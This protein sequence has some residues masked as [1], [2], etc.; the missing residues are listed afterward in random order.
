MEYHASVSWSPTSVLQ[1]WSR[2]IFL[3]LKWTWRQGPWSGKV[4]MGLV[5]SDNVLDLA[6]V[7]HQC[8]KQRWNLIHNLSVTVWESVPGTKSCGQPIGL[9]LG[10]EVGCD[11]IYQKPLWLS[12]LTFSFKVSVLACNLVLEIMDRE[13]PGARVRPKLTLNKFTTQNCHFSNFQF[14]HL[15]SCIHVPYLYHC[16]L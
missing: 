13:E 4:V 14:I 7:H 16:L 8:L 1:H 10:T 9:K 2:L 15:P 6:L 3:V 5:L 12:S 11:E